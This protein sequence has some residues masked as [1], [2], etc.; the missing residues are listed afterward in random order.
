VKSNRHDAADAEAICE[1]VGRPS[2]RFV[3]LK[4]GAQPAISGLHRMRAGFVKAR[5]AQANQIRGLLG[6]FGLFL[7]QG[8]GHISKRL[9]V[10]SLLR[11]S[12]P[13]TKRLENRRVAHA[14]SGVPARG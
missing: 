8:I 7:P 2:M 11:R 13:R 14:T 10:K 5:T 6:G 9:P 1:A 3:P 4:N 12:M